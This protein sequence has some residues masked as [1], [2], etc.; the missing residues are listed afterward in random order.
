MTE[1][2][3]LNLRQIRDTFL[4]FVEHTH[5]QHGYDISYRSLASKLGFEVTLGNT[6]QA[7]TE[8]ERRIII[9]DPN[10]SENRERFTGLHEVAHHL[11]E[12]A[13]EEYLRV[14]LTDIFYNQRDLARQYEE[15]LCNLA[16][17]RL[18]MPGSMVNSSLAKHGYGPLATLELVQNAGASVQAAARRIAWAHDFPVFVF[19]IGHNREV[20][21]CFSHGH[22]KQYPVA[23]NFTIELEHELFQQELA[24]NLQ[25]HFES[26]VPFKSGGRTWKMHTR[27]TRDE[28]G[29]ILA[30]F[31]NNKTTHSNDGMQ[32]G[33]FG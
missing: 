6:N 10:V 33:L 4:E 13:E 12:M 26:P 17:A 31:T 21:D 16:A 9:I 20:L 8:L 19:L 27:A 28:H 5:S 14:R 18:L 11:F 30:F 22:P 24:H 32:N 7:V 1:S 2:D 29:R 3:E 15:D 25:E 23:G